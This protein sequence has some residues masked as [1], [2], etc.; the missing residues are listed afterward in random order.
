[1][2]EKPHIPASLKVVAIIF[3]LGGIHSVIEV[4]LAFAHGRLSINFG[5]LGL[6]IGPGLLA[7]RPGWRACAMVFIWIALICLP[8]ATVLMLFHPGHFDFEV[9]GRQVGYVTKELGLAV[10]IAL[11]LLT[12]WEYRVLNRPDVR[13]LFGI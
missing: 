10:A 13:I 6:F 4:V 11:F 9:F 8:V 3:F 1:M 5:V 2:D 7:L 12:L